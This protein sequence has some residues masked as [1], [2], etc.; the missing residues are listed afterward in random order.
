M[1]IDSGVTASM[2]GYTKLFS[3]IL[4]TSVINVTLANGS[5]PSV[6]VSDTVNI[7]PS[8]S[9]SFVLHLLQ[10]SFNL[11]SISQITRDLNCCL[12][13]S[14]VGYC[15][16]QDLVTKKIIGKGYESRGLYSFD[17]QV[18]TSTTVAWS[19]FVFP[20]DARL[21]FMVRFLIMFFFQQNYCFLL[22]QKYLVVLVLFE[23][24]V[25]IRQS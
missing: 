2:T 16:F 1:V 17:H 7:T 8:L 15:L 25:L 21:F 24:F 20:F 14:W 5:K 3:T 18:L 12:I 19:G 22:S 13:L 23:M 10:L 9:L 6:I 11:I 4:S